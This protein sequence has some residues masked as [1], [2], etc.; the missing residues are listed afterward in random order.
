MAIAKTD[1]FYSAE[2]NAIHPFR[3]GNGRTQ[4]AFFHQL[5][6]EAGWPLDWSGLD[7]DT[8]TAAAIASLRGDNTRLRAMLDASTTHA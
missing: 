7:A 8:D 5:A 2:A 3:A 1:L 6:R 4:R